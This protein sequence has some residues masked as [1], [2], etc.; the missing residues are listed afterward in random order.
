M[1]LTTAL[2]GNTPI[3]TVQWNSP[4]FTGNDLPIQ[5]YNITLP[6]I[7]YSETVDCNDSSCSHTFPVD[8]SGD[9]VMYYNPFYEV[10]VNVTAINTCG[11]ESSPATGTGILEF[12][13]H[14][15]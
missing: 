14:G 6:E 7:D 10:A 13:A 1:S 5:T 4:T 15:Q 3:V 8:G 9:N 2:Q 11:M 12:V